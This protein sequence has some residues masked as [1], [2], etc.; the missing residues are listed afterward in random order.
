MKWFKHDSN[1]NTDAKLRRV[2]LK[3]GMA[4]YGLYWYCLELIANNVDQ[5]NITFELEHDVDIIA[6]DTGIGFELVH[7]M[8]EFMVSQG[9]FDEAGG[10]YSCIKM[11][12]RLDK[13]MTSNPYMRN[14]IERAKQSHD[15]VMIKSDKVMQDKN[16]LDKN[17]LN[18]NGR[19]SS[20]DFEKFWREYP[21]KVKKKTAKD[22]WMRKKPDA[23]ILVADIRNRLANDEQWRNGYIPHPTT[24]LNGE[25]WNDELSSAKRE[26]TYAEKLKREIDAMEARNVTN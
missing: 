12:Q 14:L 23:E 1:A 2:R 18:T 24:Y 9:L 21:K 16:R 7:E 19:A 20:T 8:M 4:G 6:A 13:S 15:K 11:A 10:I 22:I 3:Y 5:S 25:R 26:L 17:R